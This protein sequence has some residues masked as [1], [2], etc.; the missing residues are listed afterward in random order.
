MSL[1]KYFD[2]EFYI[3]KYPELKDFSKN[4]ATNHFLNIGIK[5]HRIFNKKIL[6]FDYDYFIL[7]NECE[8]KNYIK[9]CNYF[10]ENLNE[11]KFIYSSKL[12]LFEYDYYINKYSD[13]KNLA[14]FEACEHFLNEGI[15]EN[16]LFNKI[17]EEYSSNN[18]SYDEYIK[19]IINIKFSNRKINDNTCIILE[20]YF[21][22]GLKTHTDLLS[23]T[24]DIDV[25]VKNNIIKNDND[26]SNKIQKFDRQKIKDYS[27]IIFQNTNS[28]IE[29]KKSYHK[30]IYVVHIKISTMNTLLNQ[31]IIENISK[32]DYF[33]FVSEEVKIDFI[34]TINNILLKRNKETQSFDNSRIIENTIPQIENNKKMIKN[35]Y[36]CGASINKHKRIIELVQDFVKFS[37]NNY[38]E[39]K[40]ILKI[41]GNISN[42]KY[43]EEV[44]NKIKILNDEYLINNN[45]QRNN[46]WEIH[47]NNS[48]EHNEYLE[49]LKTCEYFCMYS[50]S[51][52]NSYSILEAMMLNKK[53]ICSEECITTDIERKYKNKRYLF[54]DFN[55]S[56]TKI[57]FKHDSI[58]KIKDLIKELSVKTY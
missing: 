58:N 51:E 35:L 16:R 50:K 45:I 42:N 40:R 2:Y 21:N 15:K 14:Y 43:Y 1:T 49:I 41:Y 19:H 26:C 39:N 29:N 55:K 57:E 3:N 37:N 10:I 36:I 8:H 7:N 13:I 38:N 18:S 22:F 31:N 47:L 46:V 4:K 27:I 32:I 9:V 53:I 48:L 6:N 28:L 25:L 5:E 52:G 12:E 56:K 30:F 54:E 23:K 44:K 11:L 33:I 34:S 24:L 17:L 20:N